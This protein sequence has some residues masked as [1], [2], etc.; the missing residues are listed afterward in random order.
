MTPTETRIRVEFTV[1]PNRAEQRRAYK[2]VHRVLFRIFF[3]FAIGLAALAF[4]DVV[5]AVTLL[6]RI[7]IVDLALLLVLALWAVTFPRRCG[8]RRLRAA[9]RYFA[10]PVTFEISE[11][12]AGETSAV[13]HLSVRW[14]A[15]TS[16]VE[17]SEFWVLYADRTAR[18]VLPRRHLTATDE[19]TVREFMV[20]RGLVPEQTS[21]A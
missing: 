2:I 19:A 14:A 15:V 7:P 3:W 12:E 21:E 5:L 13:G 17:T 4:A 10:N 20:G 8:S 16:V 9:P 6:H 18:L 11:V 1:P